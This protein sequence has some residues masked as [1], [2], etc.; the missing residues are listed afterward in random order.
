MRPCGVSW[1]LLIDRCRVPSCGTAPRQE[2]SIPHIDLIT[3]RG[4]T[5][6]TAAYFALWYMLLFGLQTRTKYL[7]AH[8]DHWMQIDED[9]SHTVKYIEE[10]G[11][12]VKKGD[13]LRVAFD[14]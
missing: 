6:V 8:P 1:Q 11:V 3:L 12:R 7:I 2:A 9:T 14:V 13:R 10:Q 5:T 4:P